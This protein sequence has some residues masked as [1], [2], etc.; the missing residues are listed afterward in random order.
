[1]PQ[2]VLIPSSIETEL[3]LL[4]HP[5]NILP[6]W[7]IHPCTHVQTVY[8]IENT[9]VD[10]RVEGLLTYTQSFL[11]AVLQYDLV[12]REPPPEAVGYN[13]FKIKP[14]VFGKIYSLP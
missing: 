5:F 2:I 4:V 3:V 11:S 7:L 14:F 9:A 1:M 10:V 8:P 6:S 12:D 13:C